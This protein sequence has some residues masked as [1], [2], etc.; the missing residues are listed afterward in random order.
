MKTSNAFINSAHTRSYLYVCIGAI[1]RDIRGTLVKY[2]APAE[3]AAEVIIKKHSPSA[4]ERYKKDNGNLI[5]WEKVI[6]YLDYADAFNAVTSCGEYM[7]KEVVTSIKKII[8]ALN[9]IT[10]IRNR[11]MHF[12]PLLA[13]DYLKVHSLFCDLT[14]K[15]PLQNRRFFAQTQRRVDFRRVFWF[16]AGERRA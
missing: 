15:E 1:E 6:D 2:L 12:R 7:P 13:G 14:L 16:G 5:D 4:I 9:E 8:P 11:V 3:S 10:A